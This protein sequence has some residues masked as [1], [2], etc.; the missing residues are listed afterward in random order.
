MNF[1]IKHLKV[2]SLK[3]NSCLQDWFYIFVAGD[4]RKF[5]VVVIFKGIFFV[6][7]GKKT[8]ACRRYLDDELEHAGHLDQLAALLIRNIRQILRHQLLH[9]ANELASSLLSAA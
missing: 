7:L 1:F 6:L 5:V 8:G 9:T 4:S 3:K 2:E